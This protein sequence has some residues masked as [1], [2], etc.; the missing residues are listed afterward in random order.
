MHASFLRN[1]MLVG[2]Q[3]VSARISSRGGTCTGDF[4][5]A[6]PGR[7]TF[8]SVVS[9]F[10]VTFTAALSNAGNSTLN[11]IFP[12]FAI[13]AVFCTAIAFVF[14]WPFTLLDNLS[15]LG[16]ALTL[17]GA[18][19]GVLWDQVGTSFV[20]QCFSCAGFLSV[21][22][23][24]FLFGPWRDIVVYAVLTISLS[25]QLVLSACQYYDRV[26]ADSLF[27]CQLVTTLFGMC[28][29]SF[30]T[31]VNFRRVSAVEC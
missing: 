11:A 29:T 15:Q 31:L 17:C 7:V 25:I 24:N 28:S 16:T 26:D 22:M 14:V 21:G 2:N 5:M 6:S 30:G 10:L 1:V 20:A 3:A 13:A 4:R 12:A 18:S 9:I 27:T 23:L 8:V 19:I